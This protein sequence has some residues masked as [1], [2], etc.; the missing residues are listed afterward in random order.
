MLEI[1]RPGGQ[2]T[3]QDLGRHGLRHLGIAQNGALDAP[4]LM[5]GNRLLG[6][7]ANLA[8]LEVV[9]G[10]VEIRFG[11]DGWFALT[12]AD[13]NATLD[14]EPV[15]S[16]WRLP[17]RRGQRLRLNGC[18]SGM[19]AYLCVDGGIDVPEV[20][21]AR[22]TDLKAGYGGFAGR[23]LQAGDQLPQGTAVP[24]NKRLGARLR[25]WQPLIRALPGPEYRQFDASSQQAFWQQEWTVSSQSNRMG[26]RLQ[27]APL[28]REQG[29]ELLSHAVLPGVV[30]LPPG[31]QPIVLLADAQTTGGYPR[32]ASVIEADLW[33]LAQARPGNKLRFV[34]C[35]LAT[36]W[37]A[38]ADWQHDFNCFEWSA[39][40]RGQ[41][42]PA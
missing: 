26:Y 24:L 22:A 17:C 34:E 11:R 42:Q 18:N 40:G 9:L 30:Q 39:Y 32:I 16:G 6:N 7:T 41:T 10:P 21:G 4:A 20:L 35:D 23:A 29:A 25:S 3:V 2:T 38:R 37:A 27:G 14:G 12:G 31:G 28:V 15:W 19:R 8:A 5:L 33:L 13:F 1:I 36:A